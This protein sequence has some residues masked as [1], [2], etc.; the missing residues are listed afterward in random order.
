MLYTHC[1]I[2]RDADG[3]TALMIAKFEDQTEIADFLIQNGAEL[4]QE[5][6]QTV[7]NAQIARRKEI[8]E[9]PGLLGDI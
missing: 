8:E 1:F 5:N 7:V 6:H 4:T 2:R 3:W 9:N